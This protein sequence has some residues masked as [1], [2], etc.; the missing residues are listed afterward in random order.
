MADTN[1]EKYNQLES[2]I[3]N[4]LDK[5]IEIDEEEIE[6]NEDHSSLKFSEDISSS[7]EN[8]EEKALFEKD[9]FFSH[10]L[11][12]EDNKDNNE[13]KETNISPKCSFDIPNISQKQIIRNQNAPSNINLIYNNYNPYNFNCLYHPQQMSNQN[14]NFSF[15]NIP[16]KSLNNNNKYINQIN[17]ETLNTTASY[18]SSI[19]NINNYLMMNNNNNNNNSYMSLGYN[20]FNNSFNNENNKYLF[21]RSQKNHKSF[22]AGDKI[23]FNKKFTHLSH[24]TRSNGF[25]N[26]SVEL[27]MLLIEVNKILN[28]MEKIDQA[29]FNKLKGKFEQIIRTHKGSRIFQNYLK[30]THTDIL[31]QIFLEIKNNLTELLKDNYANYFC[32]KFFDCLNQKDR[33][34]YL[35]IIQKDLK[36][37][38]VDIIATYPIQGIIEQLGSKAEKKIIYLGIKDSI[39]AFCYNVYGTHVLEKMLSYFED[40]FTKEIIE[41]IYLNFIDLAYN[42][43]GICVVKKVLLMTHKKELHQKLK[44]IVI[45]NAINLIVHQ[46]GNYVIQVIFENWDD[47]ELEEILNQYKNKYIFLSKLKY[48]SNAIERI[49]EKNQKNLDFYINEICNDKNLSELMLNNYS[50]YVIQKAIK[51]SVGKSREMLIQGILKNLYVIED[52]KIINKWK[53]IIS[54]KFSK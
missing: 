54:S 43:N 34:E 12:N 24:N 15:F 7:E 5:L 42:M 38:A 29:F 17:N 16:N 33:I 31:H 32:K 50:N 6:N 26:A 28:K 44:K 19:E 36:Y 49:I 1:K 21:K 13:I 10:F 27:E 3:E 4:M 39:D 30:N 45:D 2:R 11:Q 40:E 20:N 8:K 9:I 41:Y 14:N 46:Y 52:K 18:L 53:M 47:N 37:L 48:S 23:C 51:L 35:T 22:F 25:C